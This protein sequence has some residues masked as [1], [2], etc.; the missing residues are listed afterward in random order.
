MLKRWRWPHCRKFKELL[1]S[2]STKHWE[3]NKG[4]LYTSLEI[5]RQTQTPVSP[6]LELVTA[7]LTEA[8]WPF[9]NAINNASHSGR[10]TSNWKNQLSVAPNALLCEKVSVMTLMHRFVTRIVKLPLRIT[11]CAANVS[12]QQQ[13]KKSPKKK[14]LKGKLNVFII[15]SGLATPWQHAAP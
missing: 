4:D 2:S 5:N 13:P 1:F 7:E 10:V 9:T 15:I 14:S 6:L 8:K 3:R 12:S 11:R